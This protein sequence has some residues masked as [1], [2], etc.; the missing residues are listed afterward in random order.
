[1]GPVGKTAIGCLGVC[2]ALFAGLVLFLYFT[3][4][5]ETHVPYRYRLTISVESD[6]AVHSG[7]S[8]IQ[9]DWGFWSKAFRGWSAVIRATAASLDRVQW[10]TWARAG[11]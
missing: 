3:L 11:P 1:M 7:S 10:W 2:L 4:F 5:H 6:G 9:V 8:V